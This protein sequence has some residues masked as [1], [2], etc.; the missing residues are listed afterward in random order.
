M[1]GLSLDVWATMLFCMVAFF[2]VSIWA[3]FYT[4]RQED[5]KLALF[6]TEGDLDSYSPRALHDLRRWVEAHPDPTHPDVQTARSL[7]NDCVDTLKATDRHFYDWS[8]AEVERLDA[9]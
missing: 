4:L 3:L 5:A 6:E 8:A 1:L 2:G 7:Y 9:L